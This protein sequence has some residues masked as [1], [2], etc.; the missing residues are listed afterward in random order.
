MPKPQWR[1][2][3]QVVG[4]AEAQLRWDRVYRYLLQWSDQKPVELKTN[5]DY[6]TKPK[7]EDDENSSL[8]PR[9]YSAPGSGPNP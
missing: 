7:E 8:C 2:T 3:R 4:T 5:Q 9:I 6:Q 1:L